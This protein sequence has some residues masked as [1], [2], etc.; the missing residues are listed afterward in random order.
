GFGAAR[1]PEGARIIREAG[2]RARDVDV[3][4]PCTLA[5]LVRT[6]EEA[7]REDV[8]AY[9][10]LIP[11]AAGTDHPGAHLVHPER[12]HLGEGVRV[13]RGVVLDAS[14]GP[15]LLGPGT[16]VMANAVVTGP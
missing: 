9:A 1:A 15:I 3:S 2:L 5:D 7:L 11:S 6:N 16:H 12:I 10:R 14:A 13:D 4:W 8:A